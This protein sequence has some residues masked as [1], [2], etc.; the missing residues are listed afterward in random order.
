LHE[1]DRA[2][3]IEPEL[4]EGGE[5]HHQVCGGGEAVFEAREHVFATV[6]PPADGCREILQDRLQPPGGYL[7]VIVPDVPLGLV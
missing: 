5:L 7:R 1:R 6:G 2:A 3:R 4:A